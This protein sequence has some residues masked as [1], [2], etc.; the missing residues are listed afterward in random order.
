MSYVINCEFFAI[1]DLFVNMTLN[2]V[3]PRSSHGNNNFSVSPAPGTTTLSLEEP[4]PL[5]YL[6]LGAGRR[7]AYRHLQGHRQPT[8]LYV[9]GFF[10]PMNLRKTV[11][12]E[13][14]ALRNGYS[15]VRYDQECVGQSTGSQNTIEFEHWLEDA[16]AMVDRVCKGPV[17]LVASSLGGWVSFCRTLTMYDRG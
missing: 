10:A 17:I 16:L 4:A 5:Q 1:V 13:E 15:N 12:L 3:G 11:V 9:P 14:Y 2:T 6:E 7:I 8:L